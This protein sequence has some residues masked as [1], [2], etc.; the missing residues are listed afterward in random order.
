[1]GHYSVQL[2][3]SLYRQHGA[4]FAI[5]HAED[6]VSIETSDTALIS[7]DHIGSARQK[8][9]VYFGDTLRR[10]AAGEDGRI[11]KIGKEKGDVRRHCS[12]PEQNVV[13]VWYGPPGPNSDGA[14]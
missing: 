12:G 9:F 7:Q 8:C 6:S 10:K 13:R 5:K 4:I 1:L 3:R 11:L 2:E 14:L